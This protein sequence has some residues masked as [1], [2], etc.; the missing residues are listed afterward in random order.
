MAQVV[1]RENMAE[2]LENGSVPEFVAPGT[3][4][5]AKPEEAKPNSGEETAKTEAA[6]ELPKAEETKA[7]EPV[8]P[9]EVQKRINAKHR[10]MKEA[11]EFA[12]SQYL[13]KLAAEKRV[14]ELERENAELKKSSAPA[15]QEEEAKPPKQEDFAT[16]QEYLD[17]AVAYNVEAKLKERERLSGEK[18]AADAAA[19]LAAEHE[20]RFKA[21]AGRIPDLEEVVGKADFNLRMPLYQYIR[22]SETGP[23]LAYHLAKNP[24]IAERLNRLSP[25]KALAEL[26]KIEVALAKPTEATKPAQSQPE[27]SKAPAPIKPLSGNSEPVHK[28]PKDMTFKELRAHNEQ[29]RRL[30]AQKR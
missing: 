26:G 9:D 22:E 24:D 28:D 13:E 27:V 10:Q 14:E 25:I 8:L 12:K 11:E 3:E 17:A 1:T 16:V 5:A 21:A 23:E 2:L 30:K 7:E 15:P 4:P 18:A 20:K 19:A 29:Q 6:A